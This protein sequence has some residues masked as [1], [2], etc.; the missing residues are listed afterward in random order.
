MNL[1]LT[2]W[3]SLK[4]LLLGSAISCEVDGSGTKKPEYIWMRATE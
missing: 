4:R 3:A 1:S 2:I